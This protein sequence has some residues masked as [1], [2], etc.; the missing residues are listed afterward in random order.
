MRNSSSP[1]LQKAYLEQLRSQSLSLF[2]SLFYG[3]TEALQPES[4]G[5]SLQINVGQEASP[6]QGAV[7]VGDPGAKQAGSH[8]SALAPALRYSP[9]HDLR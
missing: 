5:K 9:A 3:E 8:W 2:V 1:G 7:M 6:T 4:E